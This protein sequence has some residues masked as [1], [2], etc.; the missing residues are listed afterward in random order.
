MKKTIVV[1]FGGRSSEYEVSLSSAYA[2]LTHMNTELYEIITVGITRQGEWL[3]YQGDYEHIKND[4]WNETSLKKVVFSP[5]PMQKQ[6]IVFDKNNIETISIDA[7]FPILHGK[8]GEDGTIQGILQIADIPV[9][10]CGLLSSALCMDKDL[11]HKVV[12]TIGVKVPKAVVINSKELTK[13]ERLKIKQLSFPLFVKPMKAGSSLGIL[14]I[15]QEEELVPAIL[16]AF[17]YDDTIIIEEN[18]DGFEVGCAIIGNKQLLIGEV[19]QIELTTGFF[20]YTEKYTLQSS[21]IHLPA[22][23]TE[24]MKQ[25]IQQTAKEIYQVLGCKVLARVDMFITPDSEIVFNEVNTIPGFTTHSRFPN[26]IKQLGL[27]FSDM[28][29]KV[30]EEG[31]NCGNDS[32][33]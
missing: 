3:L 9:I 1:I 18:I 10:G 32:T 12:S 24:D 16:H 21:K 29:D 14:K 4:T 22:N 6:I 31:L 2:T 11:A 26:M 28:L 20:D 5:E 33:S 19:D 25:N 17:S 15:T 30:I 7:A 23:I 27:S 8:N 13:E